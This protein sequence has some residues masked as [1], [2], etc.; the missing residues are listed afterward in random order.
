[1][2]E[3][4]KQLSWRYG[5]IRQADTGVLDA[6][7][8]RYIADNKL[9]PMPFFEWVETVYDPDELKSSFKANGMA[10]RIVNTILRRE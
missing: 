6:F 10:D 2:E 9:R 5:H 1:M 8:E 7:F 4:I 3:A